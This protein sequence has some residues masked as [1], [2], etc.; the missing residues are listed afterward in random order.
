MP[1][2]N[3]KRA[4]ERRN[5]LSR[6]HPLYRRKLELSAKYPSLASLGHRSPLENCPLFLCL[7]LG[8]HSSKGPARSSRRVIGGKS[9]QKAADPMRST[10]RDGVEAD[11]PKKTPRA[12]ERRTQLSP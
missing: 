1:A 12:Q 6:H 5:A 7:I 11:R 4:R 8:V 9:R 10:Q 2:R 3:L